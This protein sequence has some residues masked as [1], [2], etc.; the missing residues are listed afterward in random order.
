MTTWR[1]GEREW[2]ERGAREQD[3]GDAS[4]PFIVS[5]DYLAIAR[6]MWGWST[7]RVPTD[8][9]C[10]VGTLIPSPRGLLQSH[11]LQAGGQGLWGL[12][13]CGP[14]DR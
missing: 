7:D 12:L 2:G 9:A 13:T 8:K 4:A 11:F 10:K 3:G 5:Q 1:E 6:E 14:G